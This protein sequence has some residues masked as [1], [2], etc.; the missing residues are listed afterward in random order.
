MHGQ[1]ISL[2]MN[3]RKYVCV[4]LADV[5][6][7]KRPHN[8]PDPPTSMYKHIHTCKY[9]YTQ[10]IIHSQ[11]SRLT[12]IWN[13]CAILCMFSSYYWNAALLLLLEAKNHDKQSMN[14]KRS[15]NDSHE[16]TSRSDVQILATSHVTLHCCHSV[17][18][19]ICLLQKNNSHH[20]PHPSNQITTEHVNRQKEHL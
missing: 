12:D 15:C 2:E 9:T 8:A 17:A 6:V 3:V 10:S 16:C 13:Y 14:G 19:M 5:I 1:G 4:R 11:G 20:Q 7:E 18:G